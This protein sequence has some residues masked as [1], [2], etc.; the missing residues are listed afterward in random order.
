MSSVMSAQQWDTSHPNVSTR[1][2]TKQSTLEGKEDDLREY[3]FLAKKRATKLL[4]V[5]MKKQ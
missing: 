1:K 3:A 2:M 5:Q 4:P